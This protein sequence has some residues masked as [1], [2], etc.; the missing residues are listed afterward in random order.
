M[1]IETFVYT[2]SLNQSNPVGSTDF[3][4]EGDD[5][6][7]GIKATIKN[8]IPRVTGPVVATQHDLNTT[9]LY[10]DIGSVNNLSIEPSPQISA[11]VEGMGF[12]VKAASLNSGNTFLS[13]NG[14]GAVPIV[15]P[16][17]KYLKGGE[18]TPGSIYQFHYVNGT[19]MM[20]YEPLGYLTNDVMAV[21]S[22]GQINVKTDNFTWSGNGS[23]WINNEAPTV[24]LQDKNGRTAFI[25]V[26]QDQFYILGSSGN[27][28]STWAADQGGAAGYPMQIN[29][30]DQTVY[31]SNHT[32]TKKGS[33]ITLNGGLISYG[34]SGGR[35]TAGTVWANNGYFDNYLEGRNLTV[36]DSLYV[37]SNVAIANNLTVYGNTGFAGNVAISQ[38]LSA[39]NIFNSAGKLYAVVS[40][41][42]LNFPAPLNGNG[43]WKSESG[44]LVQ[45][46]I[47]PV[48]TG[49][50]VD[51]DTLTFPLPFQSTNY[52]VLAEDIAGSYNP[53][54][55]TVNMGFLSKISASQCFVK[56]ASNAGYSWIAIGY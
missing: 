39:P 7:R 46:G 31:F 55:K 45:W 10:S 9:A 54:G 27:N 25:H 3:V 12:R 13:I 44:F 29:L 36:T 40:Q 5:H 2:N 34:I 50:G 4:N 52:V 35:G 24:A 19:F 33:F 22:L 8:T 32:Y 47:K 42:L 30:P 14:K 28:A 11:Y 21:D 20:N 18:I 6:I 51:N 37:T 15:T 23:F 17:G 48:N 49:G 1:A 43:Y 53:T 38:V 41:S 26:N 16:K 56:T